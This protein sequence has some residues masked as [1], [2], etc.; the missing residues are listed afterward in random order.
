[1]KA[2][3]P[4]LPS[5]PHLQ[6]GNVVPGRWGP[7]LSGGPEGASAH[8]WGCSLG[9]HDG[10]GGGRG[11][12]TG[13]WGPVTGPHVNTGRRRVRA[14]QGATGPRCLP[15]VPRTQGESEVAATEASAPRLW[16]QPEL[17]GAAL[18]SE[19]RERNFPASPWSPPSM[20]CS[21]MFTVASSLPAGPPGTLLGSH[22]RHG[23]CG[24]RGGTR[25]RAWTGPPS[26]DP[27]QAWPLL[28]QLPQAV[29]MGTW[30]GAAVG[31]SPTSEEHL[32]GPQ[33]GPWGF[34]GR[35]VVG[36]F[37]LLLQLILLLSA[38]CV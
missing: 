6:G 27:S 37:P 35:A 30:E 36:P 20:G 33:P 28:A 18:A 21:G 12:A 8:D 31:V 15:G 38:Y 34:A 22:S 11:L 5:S 7:G 3:R 26:S 19:L 10:A 25:W 4:A 13:S 1:M 17:V 24:P 2:G 16:D 29:V 32:L 23:V 14:T 9:P